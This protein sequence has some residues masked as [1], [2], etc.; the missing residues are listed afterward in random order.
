MISQDIYYLRN[1][2]SVKAAVPFD[3]EEQYTQP[4]QK[5][6]DPRE[7]IIRFASAA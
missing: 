3:D 2:K 7:E 5:T 6:H 1:K 4:N